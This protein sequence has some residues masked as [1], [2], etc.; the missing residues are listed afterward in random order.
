MILGAT[1]TADFYV[2]GGRVTDL[3]TIQWM[4]SFQDYELSRHSELTSS[5]SIV[6]YVLAY[7]GGEMPETQSQLDAVL[8]KIPSSVKDQYLSGSMRGVIH[9]GM[10]NLQIPQEEN[11][12]KVMVE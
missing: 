7:N 5:T 10:I 2:Q 9:F 1:S 12:K 6:T 3:D 4:K 11:L 8:D